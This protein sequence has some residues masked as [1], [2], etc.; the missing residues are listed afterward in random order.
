MAVRH[1]H[2]PLLYV[3]ALRLDSG[4][5]DRLHQHGHGAELVGRECP[6]TI[7]RLHRERCFELVEVVLADRD[8]VEMQVQLGERNC[9]GNPITVHSVEEPPAQSQMQLPLDKVVGFVDADLLGRFAEI[10]IVQ[11]G[12]HHGRPAITRHLRVEQLRRPT[13]PEKRPP[14]HAIG[15]AGKLVRRMPGQPPD[16]AVPVAERAFVAAC[17]PLLNSR[18]MNRIRPRETRQRNVLHVFMHGE[19]SALQHE[20]AV[21]L[22]LVALEDRRG[23]YGAKRTAT[24]DDDVEWLRVGAPAGVRAGVGFIQ[25][26]A[27]VAALYVAREGCRLGESGSVHGRIP[28][29]QRSTGDGVWG[30]RR[31]PFGLASTFRSGLAVPRYHN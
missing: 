31:Q 2:E 5:A 25:R 14:S 9:S 23:E 13:A 16:F 18:E 1:H 12:L 10:A 8:I 28:L 17:L 29:A 27:D 21:P 24:H 4:S 19:R 20:D 6:G 15:K 3:I 11:V 26:I 22:L 30:G 7:A